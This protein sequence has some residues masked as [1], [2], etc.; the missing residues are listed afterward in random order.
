M[1]C[2]LNFVG[3]QVDLPDESTM[4]PQRESPEELMETSQPE[5]SPHQ[6][7]EEDAEAALPSPEAESEKETVE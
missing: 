4:S 1:S 5:T 6:E 7:P 3:V 2:K